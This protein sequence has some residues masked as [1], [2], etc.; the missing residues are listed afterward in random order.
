MLPTY[1]IT[2]NEILCPPGQ[3]W[4]T[5]SQGCIVNPNNVLQTPPL[6]TSTPIPSVIRGCTSVSIYPDLCPT[7]DA[8]LPNP[9]PT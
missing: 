1:Q 8:Y 6:A 5:A 9:S 3:Y 2:C 4:D 7:L